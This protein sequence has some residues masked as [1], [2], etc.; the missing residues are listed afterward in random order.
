M[1]HTTLIFTISII[2]VGI[3]TFAI[4]SNIHVYAQQ[5]SSPSSSSVVGTSIYPAAPKPGQHIAKIKII[6]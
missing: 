5:L 2:V 6:S 4:W 1:N 3:V